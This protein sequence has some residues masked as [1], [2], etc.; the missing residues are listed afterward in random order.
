MERAE[1]T[2][3]KL[4]LQRRV[5]E[6]KDCKQDNKNLLEQLADAD[7]ALLQLQESALTGRRSVPF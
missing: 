4:A 3:E 2:L 6:L 5:E 1:L 7:K